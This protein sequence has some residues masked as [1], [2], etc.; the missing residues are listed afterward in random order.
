MEQHI[1]VWEE[2]PSCTA[3]RGYWKMLKGTELYDQSVTY[4]MLYC[5]GCGDTK[6]V[7]AKDHRAPGV[8]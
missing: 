1:H 3:S 8:A 4:T 6:E 7:V 5:R 2:L